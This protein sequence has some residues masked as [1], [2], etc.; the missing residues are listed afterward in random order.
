M[1]LHEE[2]FNRFKEVW[3]VDFEFTAPPGELVKPICMVAKE[4][5]TGR[6]I[7]CWQDDL[8]ALKFCPFS[9]DE[10]SVV[11]AYYASAE[12]NCFI[13]LGWE[14]PHYILDLYVE[15]IMSKNGF[16]IKYNGLLS[17][18]RLNGIDCID[19]Q[20]KEEMRELAIR[21]GPFSSMEKENLLNYCASDVYALEKLIIKMKCAGTSFDCALLRG[22]YAWSV[23]CV[24]TNGIPLD[25]VTISE[26][27]KYWP[28][29]KQT[30]IKNIDKKYNVYENE[31]FKQNKFQKYLIESN[32]PWPKTITGKLEL[33]DDVFKERAKLYPEINE[34]RELRNTISKLKLNDIAIGSDERNRFLL[35]PFMS[36][37][38]R[39]QPSNSKFI[40][41]PS[42]WIRGMIK[43]EYNK[44]VAYIDWSQQ[45]FGIA[46]AL[47]KDQNMMKAYSSGDPYLEFAKQAGAVPTSGT[48][49]T[50]KNERSKF[51]AC[52]LAVQYGMGSKS[53]AE[54]LN[55]VEKEAKHLLDLHRKTYRVFWTWSEDQLNQAMLSNSCRTV[56]DWVLH[57]HPRPNPRSIA[58]FPMQA[59]G[60]E[61]MRLACIKLIEANIKV[62]APIHDAFL[63]EDDLSL[64]DETVSKVQQIMAEAS[65]IV[66][67]GF[68]LRAD[69]KV[70][71]YPDR[72]MD[73]DGEEMWIEVMKTLDNH[74]SSRVHVYTNSGLQ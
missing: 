37:T 67:D 17:A 3:A 73:E 54:K 6:E 50:H 47:S 26:L 30:L 33:S 69:A 23:A 74:K 20:E 49:R 45:E 16:D 38:G 41:G 56:F 7:R 32:I 57:V 13:Q 46:A 70:I 9:T 60:S 18:L 44:A 19:F 53:L 1:K 27:K 28:E 48:K 21:G 11:V 59:N 29:I 10:N 66:L 31:V 68:E 36:K 2:I 61:M 4:L 51:K 58:N 5:K 24:E 64:I 34:L 15:Y 52:V 62:C 71:K 63:I 55:I 65:R 25:F 14:Q 72:Y 12:M 35:S 40:F 39:N 22:E 8:S 43:P 42:R